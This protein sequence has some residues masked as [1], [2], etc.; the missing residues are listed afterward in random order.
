MKRRFF[1]LLLALALAVG[2][3]LPAGAREP[4]AGM[5]ALQDIGRSNWYY[6]AVNFCVGRGLMVGTTA[7]R[8]QA[9]EPLTRA[10]L[11]QILHRMD[12]SPMASF[13]DFSDV[14]TS[15]WYAGAVGWAA[16]HGIVDGVG[17][18]RFAPNQAI[19]R[20]QLATMLYRYMTYR[21]FVRST[22]SPEGFSDSGSIAGWAREAMGWAVANRLVQ[23]YPNGSV[24]PKEGA[25]R[26]TT[27]TMIARLYDTLLEPGSVDWTVIRS[28]NHMGYNTTHPENTGIAFIESANRGFQY[29]ETD[30]H[31]TKDR[32]PVC[33][34]DVTIDRVAL[35]ADGTA[36]AHDTRIDQLT[37]AETFQYDFG[38][39]KGEDFR[40]TPLLTFEDLMLICRGYRLSPYV[41]L[42]ASADWK[43][44]DLQNL[45]DLV[46][47][48]GMQTSVTW[49]SYSDALLR[50]LSALMPDSRLGYI[51]NDATASAVST[52]CSLRNGRN[53]V[54][55]DSLTYT[56]AQIEMCKE[57]GLPLEVWPIDSTA[58]VRQLPGYISGVT[59]NL[60]VA[61]DIRNPMVYE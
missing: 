15:S 25:T 34:H 33:L 49:I 46:R 50:Q 44:A 16:S 18:G 9:N 61:S 36:V 52:A 43:T 53:E 48:Y 22:G 19:T 51:V 1:A 24:Q 30:L 17:G 45:V 42:K 59:S 40:G 57:A 3:S 20:E 27:A 5:K 7:V 29:V 6:G 4:A 21:G 54:F 55:L 41:E 37:Y 39:Y 32:V 12:G 58:K 14:S 38:L 35:K 13:A 26:A 8:F 28:V 11:V 31:L 23:G 2:V 10:M 60:L 47:R 56:A